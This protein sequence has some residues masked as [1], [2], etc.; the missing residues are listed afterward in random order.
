MTEEPVSM[1]LV[2]SNSKLAVRNYIVYYRMNIRSELSIII[3]H[4]MDLK[5]SK[6]EN[7]QAIIVKSIILLKYMYS[8]I[9]TRNAIVVCSSYK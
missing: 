5:V 1:N 4:R 7:L 9:S 6:S 8:C 2:I 3:I